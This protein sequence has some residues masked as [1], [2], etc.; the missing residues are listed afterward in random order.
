M[1]LQRDTVQWMYW[2]KEENVEFQFVVGY[3][4]RGM[5]WW[6]EILT[7]VYVD[8]YMPYRNHSVGDTSFDYNY[9]TP[10]ARY[11]LPF[12]DGSLPN[13]Y[14]LSASRS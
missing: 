1:K 6:R 13:L 4:K 2:E 14:E 8:K 3:W 12:D 5:K 9:M 10:C 11:K 7:G